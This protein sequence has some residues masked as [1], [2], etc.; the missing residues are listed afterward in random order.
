MSNAVMSLSEFQYCI[1]ESLVYHF[2]NTPAML[3]LQG[4]IL[5]PLDCLLPSVSLP[6]LL[7]MDWE[8]G[9]PSLFTVTFSCCTVKTLDPWKIR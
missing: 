1:E 5:Q 6:W 4:S 2:T 9:Y 7:Y 8:T 3:E